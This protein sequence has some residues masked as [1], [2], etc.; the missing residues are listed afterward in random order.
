MV[1]FEVFARTAIDLLSGLA[2][3]DL[4][5][6]LGRLTQPFRHKAGLTRFLPGALN[7]AG[8]LTPLPWKGSSDVPAIAR[9]NV[10][11]VA[12][13]VQSEW[14]AGETMPVILK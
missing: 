4:R 13:A 9:A 5:L 12:D 1:T 2:E 6:S 10:F 14:Q 11:L 7:G 3:P 8:E